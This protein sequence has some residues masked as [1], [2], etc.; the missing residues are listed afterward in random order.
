M[1]APYAENYAALYDDFHRDKPYGK[2]TEFL[3]GKLREHG[4]ERGGRILELACGTGEHAL[5]LSKLGYVLTA[6]DRSAA[7]IELA[8]KKARRQKLTVRFLQCD[9]TKLPAPDRK[10]DAAIC[11]FDS[12]GY[13]K[14]DER[15]AALLE[16]VHRSVR[17]GGLFILEFWHAPAMLNKYDPVR[18][19]H[20]KHGAATVFR[21]SE[22]QLMPERSLAQVT[23]TV[24]ELRTN[25]TYRKFKE[26]HTNRYFTIAEMLSLARARG[27]RPLETFDGFQAVPVSDGTWHVLAIWRAVAKAGTA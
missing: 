4:I 11:L 6:T 10:F 21:V 15:I 22:T 25:A 2:E 23:Y 13:L 9:M 3:H 17:P 20:V 1:I 14:T 5:R 12:I 7:M 27:F 24:Y 16:C 18:L 8:R 26:R 19:R